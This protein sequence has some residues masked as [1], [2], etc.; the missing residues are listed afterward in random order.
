MKKI[1]LLL[2]LLLVSQGCVAPY[3]PYFDYGIGAVY[4]LMKEVERYAQESDIHQGK[5]VA[6]TGD[7][8]SPL[9]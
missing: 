1:I 8:D 9:R 2:V 6:K 4:N 3:I 7:K 5:G